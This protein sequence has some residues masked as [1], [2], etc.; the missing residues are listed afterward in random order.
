[1]RGGPRPGAGRPKG[2]RN[3][4][5]PFTRVFLRGWIDGSQPEALAAWATIKDPADK[6]RT[7]AM[8]AEFAYPKLA[9]Q[10]VSGT[11]GGP[12]QIVIQKYTDAQ[13]GDP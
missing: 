9:R 11:D 7:W 6:V 13:E 3:A 2:S 1:M 12:V 5:N 4:L 8:L 10:E